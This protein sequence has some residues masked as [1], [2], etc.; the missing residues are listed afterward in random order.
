MFGT[1]DFEMNEHWLLDGEELGLLKGKT[2]PGRLIFSVLLKYFRRYQRF[3]DRL[4][5]VPAV[6]VDYLASQ[7][8][9]HASDFL[10]QGSDRMLRRFR[11]EVRNYLGIRRFNDR[12]AVKFRQWLCSEIFLEGHESLVLDEKVTQWLIDHDVE[13]PHPSHLARLI[14]SEESAFEA[15]LFK[16]VASRLDENQRKAL[17]LLLET[18]EGISGF[19][20]LKSDP[21]SA[22]LQSVIETVKRL[23]LLQNLNLP[24]S[25]IEDIHPRLAKRLRARAASDDVWEMRRH[26][27]DV[28]LALLCIYCIARKAEIIDGLIDLLIGITH[29]ISVRAEQKVIAELVRDAVK[30]RGKTGLLF[31]I[32][33]AAKEAPNEIVR[34]AIFPVVGED[35]L[36][37]LIK[38]YHADGPAYV[39]KIYRRV[40]ASYARHYRRM[41]P[42]ILN[43]L[44]FHSNNTAWKPVLEGLAALRQAADNKARYMDADDVPIEG[45]VARKWRDLVLEAGPRD[46]KRI[47]CINY[48]ICVL[49]SLRKAL[50]SKEVWVTDAGRFC[51]P[52]ND[53]PKDFDSRKNHYYASLDRPTDPWE[54]LN[55]IKRQMENSLAT[56]DAHIANDPFVQLKYRGSKARLLVKPIVPLPD[57]PNL[58]SFKQELIR[59]WPSTHLIDVMKETDFH[60]GFTRAFVSSA[61]R[62]SLDTAETTRRLLLA[63]YGLGTNMGLKAVASGSNQVS[64]K[65]L[66]HIKRRFIDQASL[67][68]AIRLVVNA[69]FKARSPSLWGA[70]TTSCAS[71][72]TQFAAWDQNLMTEWH[73]RYGGRGIM[74]Y[75]HVDNNATCIYSQLKRCSSS[76][77]ASMIEGVLRHGTDTDIERQYVDTHGQ[78]LIAFAICALLGFDLMPRLK[79]IERQ[80]LVRPAPKE[81]ATYTNI[82]PLFMANPVR[83]QLIAPYYDEMI[84]IVTALVERTAEPEAILRRFTRGQNQHPVYTALLEL[85]KAVKTTFLCR[86]LSS[87]SLRREIHAG[88]NVVENWNGLNSFIY[89]GKNGE[90]A[91]N[92][93]EAQEISALSLHLVQACLVHVNTLMIEEVLSDEN[94]RNR[95]TPRDM[96]GITPLTH[97]HFNPYGLIDV[98][99]STRLPLNFE[100][101]AA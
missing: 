51:N 34:K 58:G 54:F 52:D 83:W 64:Y 93:L 76:E 74:I 33:M 48:E 39:N 75:W 98:D 73:R 53:L 97:G 79:G 80:K 40:R 23:E 21:G 67:R 60:S 84:K 25:V 27:L 26:P 49:H 36:D 89:F 82:E 62:Q 47:N 91:A 55:D 15:R 17:E 94:W 46:T 30:V 24:A 35:V 14:S 65:E 61:S 16:D 5:N 31:R 28:R 2:K 50:R 59:R 12:D 19:S 96:A 11:N 4:Q 45:V 100:R 88:L 90:F 63:L 86:Y 92:Q 72:S 87:E 77:V 66:L 9:T 10:V 18:D 68:Q 7:I 20:K 44:E 42:L 99:M 32:A 78:S 38:E 8:G 85:G 70:G 69:T 3:P 56:F 101:M 81:D 71:D 57:P 1:T 37:D 13:R 22:S 43:A 6:I 41:M 95:M 29:K